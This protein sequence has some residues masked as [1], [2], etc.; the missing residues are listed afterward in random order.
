MREGGATFLEG[1]R[2]GRL[3]NPDRGR[4]EAAVLA[5]ARD[6]VLVLSAER[7]DVYIQ[8]WQ[9]P[10]GIF[11][12]EHRAGSPSEHYQTLTVSAE[13]VYTA[14]D[15]WRRAADGWESPFTWRL[16]DTEVE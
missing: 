11:Q 9:R 5:L 13:K 10:D 1:D 12:L 2:V 16:I 14:F 3:E 8:V 7:D 15:A 6:S 4:I